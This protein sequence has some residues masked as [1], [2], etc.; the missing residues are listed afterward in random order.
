MAPVTLELLGRQ[1][2][3]MLSKIGILQ[4]AVD[5]A[6][7]DIARI[8]DDVGIIKADMQGL[9]ADINNARHETRAGFETLDARLRPLENA[10]S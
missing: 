3:R 9:R 2:E 5:I 7:R 6:R 1:M 8:A 4:G 10:D